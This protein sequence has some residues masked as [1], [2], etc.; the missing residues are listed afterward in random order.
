M[1]AIIRAR[2]LASVSKR[3]SK[4]NFSAT[5]NAPKQQMAASSAAFSEELP[6]PPRASGGVGMRL[7]KYGVIASVAGIL[8]TTGYAT[9]GSA[10][11]L[12]F[13]FN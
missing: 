13:C 11:C 3:F 9:Y 6:P 4:R 10:K 7:L 8:G 1:S 2:L 5:V 12:V